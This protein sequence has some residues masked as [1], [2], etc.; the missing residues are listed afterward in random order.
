M[1][2]EQA[3]G[4]HAEERGCRDPVSSALGAGEAQHEVGHGPKL[5]DP[6]KRI[7]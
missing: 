3:A 2:Y 1:S 5:K 7:M 6:P 4:E